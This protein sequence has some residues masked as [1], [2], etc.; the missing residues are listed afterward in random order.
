VA[1]FA[2]AVKPLLVVPMTGISS[3][4]TAAGYDRPKFLLEADGQLVIDHVIDMYPG[5]DDVVFIC[6][7]IHLDD[8]RFDLE[9]HLL[10]RR[11]RATVVRVDR[12]AL[13][14]GDAVL[15]ARQHIAP[16]LPV[17]V[18]YC[19]FT[20]YQDSDLLAERLTSGEL[21]GIIPVYT[22]GHPHMAH[23]TSYA[24]VRMDGDRVVDIQEK[25]PWTDDPSTEFASSGTYAFASGRLL[26]DSLEQQIAE[27]HLLKGEYYLSLTYKPLLARGGRVEVLE[28]Q[29]FMQWGTPQ[30]FEEYR[31]ASRAIAGWTA[32]RLRPASDGAVATP[33]AR[34]VLASGAGQRFRDAGYTLPKPALPLAG[35]PVIEHALAGLPGEETVVVTREDLEDHG[36]VAEL[37]TRIDARLVSLPGL[38]QG[39]AESALRGLE[40]VSADGPVTVGACDALPTVGREAVE[41]ALA[42]AGP[43]GLIVWLARPY[44][45]AARRP[46][47]YGWADLDAQ[48]AV[49]DSWLK[50]RPADPTAGVMI[51]TFTFGSRD[52]GRRAIE[53]LMA[54]D[55]R[56][57]GEFYLDSLVA[58]VAAAGHPVVGLLVDGFSSVGTPAEYEALRYWQSCFHKWVHHPYALAADPLVRT[59]DRATLDKEF[60]T[61]VRQLPVRPPVL[62]A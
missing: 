39:Q 4:F 45:A 9:G 16:D 24:Y 15:H 48:G 26:L 42:T 55:E 1:S 29:H 5:W 56:I 34:V 18:N 53:S 10:R 17:V 8:P 40:A 11:P 31:D 38:T 59:T 28:L 47:Q 22:G 13:G 23:S 7:A 46:E 12:P 60:R 51:G 20:A 57:N 25:Q 2:Q 44:H 6:N 27:G 41:R 14:P 54:D 58:R 3:R 37:T 19:D 36:A 33:S 50:A 21:D 49:V 61:F 52:G 62:T 32:P 43:D 35:R 30:D